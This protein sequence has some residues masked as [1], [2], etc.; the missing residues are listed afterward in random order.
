MNGAK[1]RK[2][3][4]QITAGLALSCVAA[5]AAAQDQALYAKVREYSA[6]ASQKMAEGKRLNISDPAG[7][8]SAYTE[9]DKLLGQAIT[10]FK[11][12]RLTYPNGPTEQMDGGMAQLVKAQGMA[13][14][15][16]KGICSSM[17]AAVPK[18]G[19]PIA[20]AEAKKFYQLREMTEAITKAEKAE[21]DGDFALN[22][23]EDTQRAIRSYGGGLMRFNMDMRSWMV[24][25]TRLSKDPKNAIDGSRVTAANAYI[26]AR[27]S[28]L[29]KKFNDSCT[30]DEKK[31]LNLRAS[32]SPPQQCVFFQNK[33]DRYDE[34][35]VAQM[36]KQLEDLVDKSRLLRK[37][38]EAALAVPGNSITNLHNGIF[39]PTP[40]LQLHLNELEELI[41][42]AEF[43]KLVSVRLF[44]H[45]GQQPPQWFDF[46]QAGVYLDASK[47][48]IGNE[49]F[50]TCRVWDDW[51]VTQS[52]TLT[53]P[54]ECDIAG[55]K[56]KK[57]VTP[58]P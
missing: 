16:A 39:D 31:Y 12:F 26:E 20:D 33:L 28:G 18:Q 51:L 23:L 52:Q 37:Q 55:V 1:F 41:V 22:N 43:R 21:A 35:S 58:S 25:A 14:S 11:A 45:G 32:W 46:W 36:N 5:P 3:A 24:D 34:N 56:L 2:Y 10:Q 57:A 15:E 42:A 44:V 53:R 29:R 47:S 17:V 48:V 13:Q 50:M 54:K 4:A 6:Q 19:I 38:S 9:S 40:V 30:A 8:C 49:I 27:F 7:S